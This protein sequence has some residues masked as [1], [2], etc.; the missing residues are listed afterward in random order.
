MGELVVVGSG[1][2]CHHAAVVAC[3]YDAAAACGG[4]FRGNEVGGG[5]SG[6]FVHGA[7]GRGIGIIANATEVENG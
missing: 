2:V 4:A 3:D 7:K 6:A 1:K 5:E